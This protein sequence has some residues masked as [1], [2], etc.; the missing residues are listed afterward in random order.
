MVHNFFQIYDFFRNSRFLIV[1]PLDL[2]NTIQFQ[3]SDLSRFQICSSRSWFLEFLSFVK[4]D[5]HIRFLIDRP[6]S[7]IVWIAIWIQFWNTII[8]LTYRSPMAQISFNK[9][10]AMLAYTAVAVSAFA[11]TA[12][13]Q[14]PAPAP[15]SLSGDS[16]L[17][18]QFS[19][20]PPRC[21]GIKLSDLNHWN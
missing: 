15:K 16:L 13:A 14:A 12:S 21:S 18:C 1:N 20:L 9:A 17:P 6:S 4:R 11:V 3:I 8:L 10:T 2:F 7:W 5:F 19:Y